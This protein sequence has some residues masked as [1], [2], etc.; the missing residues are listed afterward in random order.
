MKP[1]KHF[2]A[3]IAALSAPYICSADSIDTGLL[4]QRLGIEATVA[5]VPGT[6]AYLRGENESGKK[7]SAYY[8]A[9]V[10]GDFSMDRS[11]RLGRLYPGVYQGLGLE[12]GSF[13]SGGLLGNPVS[14]YV[15]QGAVPLRIGKRL[16]LGY[17]WQFGA[18]MGWTHY[19]KDT[20]TDNIAVSTSVTARMGLGIR[21]QYALTER[22]ALTADVNATHFSN[23]NTSWPNRGVNMTGAS[24]GVAYSLDR[25]S[26]TCDYV[27]EPFSPGWIYDITAY[28]AWRKRAVAI[29]GEAMMCPGK[30]GVAGLQFSPMRRFNQW[31]A[32]GASL[33][34]QY[35]ESA[36]LAQYH[37]ENT[38]GDDIKFYR[39]PFGK[40]L[41]IGV[42]ARAE[43]IM[44]VFAINVGVGY[45]MLSPGDNKRFYQSLALKA[46]VTSK[47]FVNVGY[48]LGEFKD[49]QNMM[50]G[51]G[52]RL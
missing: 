8:G 24:I 29:D 16:S 45:D 13:V 42:S 51:L 37:V 43:L 52:V 19:R 21:L 34:M 11:T 14:L 30:F 36:C 35:D 6:N 40:Q 22:I 25:D 50:L 32:A 44:P 20:D 7:V 2:I 15:Y 26:G 27:A 28:G 5:G 48:R 18:A 47:L 9:A 38:W 3:L 31:F 1:I 12:F 46:F 17:E 33:D 41:S 10:R 4:H 23:G 39:P 49:P